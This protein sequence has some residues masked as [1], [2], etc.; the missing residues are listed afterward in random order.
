M[1]EAGAC[2]SF[3]LLVLEQEGGFE[4]G[5]QPPCPSSKRQVWTASILQ[6]EDRLQE[7]G[8][9]RRLDTFVDVAKDRAMGWS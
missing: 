2:G 4:G 8:K 6:I 1:A 5:L 3:R 7:E 9:G